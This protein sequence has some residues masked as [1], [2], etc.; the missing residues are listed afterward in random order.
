MAVALTQ[1][2]VLK[3]KVVWTA[4]RNVRPGLERR[5]EP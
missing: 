1:F 3:R 5:R 4:E 2:D